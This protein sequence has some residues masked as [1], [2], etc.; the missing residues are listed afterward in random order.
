M[1]YAGHEKQACFGPTTWY[2]ACN[3]ADTMPLGAD[4]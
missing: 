4:W 3:P 2:Y 1:F